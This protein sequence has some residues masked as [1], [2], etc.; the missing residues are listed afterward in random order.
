MQ[1]VL[2]GQAEET[3]WGTKMLTPVCEE[4]EEEMMRQ[5][6]EDEI[7]VAAERAAERAA[8]ATAA[9]RQQAV[10]SG[11]M[12]S[13]SDADA[14]PA[15]RRVRDYTQPPGPSEANSSIRGAAAAPP[16]SQT[17][18]KDTGTSG[19]RANSAGPTR[20]DPS[21]S[22]RQVKG[23]GYGGNRD[24]SPNG[25]GRPRSATDGP[26]NRTQRAGSAGPRT[27]KAAQPGMPPLPRKDPLPAAARQY[28]KAGRAVA[29]SRG[30]KPRP[31][32]A[33]NSK[34]RTG[35]AQATTASSSAKRRQQRLGY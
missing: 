2:V 17:R 9:R 32:S 31:S 13:S 23:S 27:R 11:G 15:R 24:P 10:H 18:V 19:R 14:L 33:P 8:A 7:L 21:P 16:S 30:T 12:N 20:R 26:S 3:Q 4:R 5:K 35:V 34:V 25:R 22:G 28:S 29:S 6:R 1:R